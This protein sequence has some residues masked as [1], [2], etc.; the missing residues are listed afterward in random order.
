MRRCAGTEQGDA[1]GVRHSLLAQAEYAGTILCGLAV[2]GRAGIF[3]ALA[4]CAAL[5]LPAVV[6]VQGCGLA[7]RCV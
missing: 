6:V 5:L 4:V 2:A 1:G 7:R 3:A